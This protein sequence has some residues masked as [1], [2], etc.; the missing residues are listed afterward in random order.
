MSVNQ[1][2]QALFLMIL[3]S[4]VAL[5]H[6][7]GNERLL[8]IGAMSALAYNQDE[9]DSVLSELG[10]SAVRAPVGKAALY[11]GQEAWSQTQGTI[12]KDSL[13]TELTIPI[14][15]NFGANIDLSRSQYDSRLLPRQSNISA[16]IF[17]NNPKDG[18]FKAGIAE[19]IKHSSLTPTKKLNQLS[20]GFSH[21]DPENHLVNINL[22]KARES[23]EI[24]NFSKT[25]LQL[26]ADLYSRNTTLSAFYNSIGHQAI[27]MWLP[28]DEG[29]R[30]TRGVTGE[31]Y[32][33]DYTIKAS[34]MHADQFSILGRYRLPST[35]QTS[36]SYK[37]YINEN[38]SFSLDHRKSQQ[39][40]V[41]LRE[42]SS[43]TLDL[44]WRLNQFNNSEI[45]FS[46]FDAPGQIPNFY[47]VRY[48]INF[49]KKQSLKSA[50]RDRDPF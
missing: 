3:G 15:A 2:L 50:D 45:H 30:Y 23:G 8:K 16:E 49:G 31:Y 21:L 35:D 18:S 40:S 14:D 11:L 46:A 29:T 47:Q 17:W 19:S 27:S 28:D 5:A 44:R 43:N 10:N 39:R 25:V 42:Y 33:D 20:V 36:I 6:N 1:K 34:T 4:S 7:V 38:T 12:I 48:T 32:T 41:S 13:T 26:S 37:H 9:L 24:N 22:I